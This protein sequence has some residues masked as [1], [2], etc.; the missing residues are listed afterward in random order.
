MC[1]PTW[2]RSFAFVLPWL[3]VINAGAEVQPHAKLMVQLG[4]WSRL[5]S[6]SL[7]RDGRYVLTGSEDF[8]AVLWDA[9]SGI[10]I[11]QFTG[12]SRAVTS[13]ALSP[14]NR[15]VATA[16]SDGTARLWDAT[17]GKEIRKFEG[18]TDA[19]MSVVFSS[20][21]RQ[22]LTGGRDGTA[23]LWD[24]E[25]G[26]EIERFQDDRDP[27]S[28]PIRSVAISPDGKYVLT[29]GWDKMARLWDAANGKPI[30]RFEGHS[31]A[32]L[33][34]AFSLDGHSVAT[35]SDDNTVRVW[36]TESGKQLRRLEGH[37]NAVVS[38]AFSP[39]GGY[40]IT[41]SRDGTAR[42]WEVASGREV[43]RFEGHLNAVVSVAFS[44]DGRNVLTASWDGSAK[45]WDASS[46]K[47]IRQFTG[48]ANYVTS[49]TFSVDGQSLLIGSWDSTAQL[50]DTV[51]GVQRQRLV[52]H[53]GG[54]FSAVFSPNGGLLATG[55]EDKTARL[56]DAATGREVRRFE[57]HTERVMSVAMS[58]SGKY[59]LTGSDDTTARLW[60]V[61]TGQELRRF[62]GNSHGV[63]SVAISPD[64]RYVLTGS[65]SGSD[66]VDKRTV[67]LWD[68]ANGKELRQYEGQRGNVISVAFSPDGRWLLSGSST[69]ETALWDSHREGDLLKEFPNIP[70]VNP[71][72]SVNSVA[73]SP[74]A[75]YILTG[76]LD[77]VASLWD[78]ASGEKVRDFEGHTGPVQSVAFSRDGSL[79]LT[80]SKDGTARLWNVASG[81][82]LLALIGFKD[83]GWAVVDPDGRFD[84]SDLDG[85]APLHWIIEDDPMHALPLEIFMRDYYTPRLLSRIMNGEQLPPIRSIAEIRNRVQPDVAIVS[86]MESKKHAGSVNI[87]VRAT[88]HTNAKGQSSGLKDLR[89]FRNGQL[90]GYQE[91]PLI[92]G[93]F[94][95]SDVQLPRSAN[96]VTFTAYAFNQERIK[97][98]TVQRVYVYEPEPPSKPRAWLLQIGVNLYRAADCELHGSANDAEALSRVL[99]ERL[100]KRGLEV[101]PV[102]LVSTDTEKGATKQEIR[103]ALQAIAEEATPDDVFFLSFSGHGYGDKEGQFYILPADFQ[104]RCRGVSPEMLKSAIS[105][106]ELADWLRP[107]DA[108]EMTFVLDS[109]DSAS[110]VES[111][112][113]K[114]GPM[115]SRGLGQLAYDKRMRILAASQSN[116]AAIE[117]TSLHQGLLSYALTQEG[118]VEG[119]ADWKPVDQKI[120]VGEWLGFAADEV[121]RFR[122]RGEV[123]T[124]RG[125]IPIGLPTPSRKPAQTPAVFDF[126]KMDTFVLQ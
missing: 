55:S 30:R 56:W 38:V 63:N 78:V 115:G 25:S 13:S 58:H 46:A 101:R 15:F 7:S 29:G 69:G 64:D 34:V 3:G 32:V 79:I 110:S 61:E 70:E 91:G 96:S 102:R 75:R 14:D 24:T 103:D 89:L 53:Q 23:R 67:R 118:L 59:L 12:H 123:K 83:G 44:S 9:G 48:K 20:D 122:E 33:S 88:S 92:E 87:V 107:I 36:D 40:L 80:G 26:K 37:S 71:F 72:D 18:H 49:V 104:G 124:D 81:K 82:E 73:F 47:E 126:S 109:C 99:S 65:D 120:T 121:P 45:L 68:L 10:E 94:T 98:A 62:E 97:S 43:R 85:G 41:G 86:I 105:A 114:P 93:D 117:S 2:V 111:N 90:V 35:G 76:R 5:S 77:G 39:D 52:G 8:T 11:R 17:T 119:K 112:D 22:V 19:V 74:D 51:T 50:W 31:E 42:L 116:Q 66:T 108:G 125:L 4:H 28:G 57:G 21:G 106:N 113:F 54:I 1:P 6:A 95:F 100:S 27:V 84:T 60:D 16:S